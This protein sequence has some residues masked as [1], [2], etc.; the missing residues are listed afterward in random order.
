MEVREK[1]KKKSRGGYRERDS[2]SPRTATTSVNDSRGAARRVDAGWMRV[3]RVE[4]QGGERREIFS[5]E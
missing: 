2:R 4:V 3:L 5:G 1:E